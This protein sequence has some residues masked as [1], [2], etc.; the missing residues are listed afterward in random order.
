MLALQHRLAC[1]IDELRCRR[2]PDASKDSRAGRRIDHEKS[3]K[4]T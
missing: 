3:T 4:E 2:L 1:I